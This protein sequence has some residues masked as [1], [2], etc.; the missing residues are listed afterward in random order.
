MASFSDFVIKIL[1]AGS[2]GQLWALINELKIVENLS[3][4]HLKVPG[5]WS[6][7]AIVLGSLTT[8]TIPGLEEYIDD[9]VYIPEQV[10]VSLN[11]LQAGYWTS[12]FI[13]NA[14]LGLLLYFLQC[15]LILP[16]LV[17][18]KLQRHC[19]RKVQQL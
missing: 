19:P 3:L 7:F 10:P 16:L 15:C 14:Q 1:L 5:S 9:L 12:L 2:L 4:F 13:K 17:L 8:L 18:I 11:F 6:Y